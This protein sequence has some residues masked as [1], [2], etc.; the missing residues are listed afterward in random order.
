MLSYLTVYLSSAPNA[1]CLALPALTIRSLIAAKD[2]S[3][4]TVPHSPR[5]VDGMFSWSGEFVGVCSL[6]RLFGEGD[7]GAAGNGS[8]RVVIL[9]G[10]SGPFAI[11]VSRLGTLVT[12]DDEQRLSSCDLL[13]SAHGEVCPHVYLCP[14]E[15]ILW[16]VDVDA[17][18]RRVRG[19]EQHKL[20]D[21]SSEV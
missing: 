1:P 7:E 21:Q 10:D 17:L 12:I 5:H 15:T 3:I 8:E 16:L 14:D 19:V 2:V 9:E 13:G 6:A 18:E 4:A 11:R 20:N